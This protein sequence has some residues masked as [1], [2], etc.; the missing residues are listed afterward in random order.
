MGSHQMHVTLLSEHWMLSSHY[1]ELLIE[2][3]EVR[4]A[5]VCTIFSLGSCVLASLQ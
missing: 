2:L 1:Y 4:N 5:M 3:V